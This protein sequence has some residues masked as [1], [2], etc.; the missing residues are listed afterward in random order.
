MTLLESCM[1]AAIIGAVTLITV[2][3]LLKSRDD[4]ALHTAAHDV[5]TK[6]NLARIHAVSRNR[7]CRLRVTSTVSYAVE[8]QE[9]SNWLLSDAI[10]VPRGVTIAANAKPEFHR[11]GNVSPTATITLS[12]TAG[13]QKKV[14]VNNGGRIR[15][16]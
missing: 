14:V 1:S 13:R 6:M 8:C 2:P 10:V 12:N 7:D 11:L 15:I 9:G 5:A 3:A 16:D 4:Y